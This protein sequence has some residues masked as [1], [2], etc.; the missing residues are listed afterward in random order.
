MHFCFTFPPR[1]VHKAKQRSKGNVR[2]RSV[3]ESVPG[4]P[5]NLGREQQPKQVDIMQMLSKAQ[6][7]YNQVG[8]Y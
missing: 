5:A 3:S 2:Q 8:I 4:G 6:D 1:L 7:E